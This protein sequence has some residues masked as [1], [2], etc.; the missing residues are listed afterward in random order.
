MIKWVYYCYPRMGRGWLIFE[1]E[2]VRSWLAKENMKLG[3]D[4][5]QFL[6]LV[7]FCF[8]K[9][10]SWK[11]CRNHNL[12]PL[13]QDQQRASFPRSQVGVTSEASALSFSWRSQNLPPVLFFLLIE[14]YLNRRYAIV[15]YQTLGLDDYWLKAG[16]VHV[17]LYAVFLRSH[18]D[19]HLKSLYVF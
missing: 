3:I 6:G 5:L 7:L 12:Y 11:A 13:K 16:S 10:C 15:S 19:I 4:L 8:G 17:A 1:N 2:T 9:A 14:N 18:N